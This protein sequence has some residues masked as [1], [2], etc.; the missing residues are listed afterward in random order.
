[1]DAAM[2]ET[3]R[4][5]LENSPFIMATGSTFQPDWRSLIGGLLIGAVSAV[6]SSFITTKE[7]AVEL[8]VQARAID[9]LSTRLESTVTTLQQRAEQ[10]MTANATLNERLARVEEKQNNFHP[11]G[12]AGMSGYPT[13]RPR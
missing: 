9:Q 4:H 5:L 12:M 2:S 7:L 13:S 8:R 11:N 10:L 1:M 3:L 6:T